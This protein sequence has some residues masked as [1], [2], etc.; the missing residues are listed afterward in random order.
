VEVFFKPTLGAP[1]FPATG[2][3]GTFSE[4]KQKVGHHNPKYLESVIVGFVWYDA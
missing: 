3:L 1:Q 4:E 2:L